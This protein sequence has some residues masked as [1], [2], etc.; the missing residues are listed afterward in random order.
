MHAGTKPGSVSAMQLPTGA[1]IGPPG[2]L[3]PYPRFLESRVRSYA[4]AGEEGKLQQG[5]VWVYM[6]LSKRGRGSHG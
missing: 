2:P 5:V 6:G 3:R 1:S 4:Q